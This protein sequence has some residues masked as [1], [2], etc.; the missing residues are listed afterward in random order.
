MIR[1]LA[2][3]LTAALAVLACASDPEPV[4]EPVVEDVVVVEPEPEP[5]VEEVVV[6]ETAPPPPVRVALPKT[7]SA[8]PLVGALGASAFGLAGVVR[9]ARRRLLRRD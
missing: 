7:A 6:V 2:I 5:V 8:M 3:A 9:I 4:P 1:I